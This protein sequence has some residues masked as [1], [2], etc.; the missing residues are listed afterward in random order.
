MQTT[1]FNGVQN[2]SVSYLLSNVTSN[3]YSFN[4]FLAIYL[5]K[6][7]MKIIRMDPQLELLP[8]K[9]YLIVHNNLEFLICLCRSHIKN[10][11]NCWPF[12]TYS[13]LRRFCNSTNAPGQMTAPRLLR[14]FIG[15]HAYLMPHY[16]LPISNLILRLIRT[17]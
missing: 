3:N 9:S 12:N 6:G 14:M 11:S 5:Q 1:Y 13:I 2:F 8:F 15:P 17:C 16:Q 10:K 7:Y 4:V